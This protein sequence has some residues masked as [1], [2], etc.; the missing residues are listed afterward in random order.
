MGSDGYF[1]SGRG[2]FKILGYGA[3]RMNLIAGDVGNQLLMGVERTRLTIRFEKI[4]GRSAVGLLSDEDVT[5]YAEALR[6]RGEK[7]T[8]GPH[9]NFKLEDQ[10]TFILTAQVLKVRW[11]KLHAELAD[12]PCTNILDMLPRR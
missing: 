12:L 4:T 3:S 6:S 8:T 9:T 2:S 11:A 5:K 10:K 7:V 1:N